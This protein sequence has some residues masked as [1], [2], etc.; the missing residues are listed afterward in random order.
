MQTGLP[1][2]QKKILEEILQYADLSDL[3][4]SFDLC[5]R[6]PELEALCF[7]GCLTICLS[8][9]NTL[10]ESSYICQKRSLELKDELIELWWSKL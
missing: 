10:R 3:T 5:R 7:L 6:Q 9:W 2:L 4:R 1:P 8:V